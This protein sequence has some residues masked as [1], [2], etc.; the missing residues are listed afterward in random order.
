MNAHVV[1]TGDEVEG[2]AAML[3]GAE[4]IPDVLGGADAELRGVAPFVDRARPIQAF[5]GAFELVQNVVV[6]QQ[7]FHGDGR[8]DGLEVNELG[9]CHNNTPVVVMNVTARKWV[10]LHWPH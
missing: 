3:A 6:A 7:L 4:T 2:V 10:C 1:H 8:F 9:F 5:A